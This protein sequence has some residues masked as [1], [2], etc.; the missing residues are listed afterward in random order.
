MTEVTT[1]PYAR[2]VAADEINA[3]PSGK[4]GLDE[5]AASIAAKGLI[6]PLCV[7]PADGNRFEVIDGGRRYRAIGRLVKAKTWK[8][9]TAIP[10]IVRNE[11]DAEALETSLMAN[12][13]RLPMH[14]VDQ[15]MVFARLAATGKSDADIA[16]RFGI[17]ER[18]VRQQQ[19]LGKL[20]PDVLDA[21]R[22][23]KIDAKVAQA[24][25][26]HPDQAVQAAAWQRLKKRGGAVSDY[27][28]RR[29][30]AGDR[31][32]KHGV[33]DDLLELY[34]AA[35]GTVVDDLFGDEAYLEDGA[36]LTTIRARR[37]AEQ[38]EAARTR[39]LG[40][41]WAWVALETDLPHG[42]KWEWEKL[43]PDWPGLS[44]E[45]E[46]RVEAL[47]EKIVAAED[48]DDE[49]IAGRLYAE[50]AAIEEA[51]RMAIFTPE[52]R[53]RS[54]CVLSFYTNGE[55]SI[56]HG[57]VRPSA[58]GTI[59]IETA[60]DAARD[61]S[62]GGI[63]RDEDADAGDHD[64]GDAGGCGAPAVDGDTDGDGFAI[65]QAL[66]QTVSEALTI[67]AARTL[68]GDPDLAMRVIAAALTCRYDAPAVVRSEGHH[69]V[70]KPGERL[71]AERL[72]ELLSTP[73]DGFTGPYGVRDALARAVAGT[74]DLTF[75]RWRY[76]SRDDGVGA[77]VAALP[78]EAFLAMAREAFVVDD[79]FTRASKSVALAAID[80][81]REA[82]CAAGMAPEDTLATMRKADLAAAA[83]R[84]AQACGWLPPE[85]RNA[86]YAPIAPDVPLTG[87]M[88]AAEQTGDRAVAEVGQP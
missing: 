79:Y 32:A 47:A 87:P 2:L 22:K 81:M 46:A 13:V 11:D 19:A 80:E 43:R 39:L 75:T 86:V 23:G 74:L 15:H 12:T 28:V 77:L 73:I 20:A 83:A 9:D 53:A 37:M 33:P 54:G 71:F 36:L 16:A 31:P 52:M 67:A 76:K 6:Q 84:A 29:E 3:R 17:T 30:L 70:R 59:D 57:V 56:A 25:C 45:D 50:L 58:D 8:R 34:L 42:W 49:T 82:G 72:A 64:K 85:L 66:A 40:Q 44:A 62:D 88:A 63:D 51:S 61:H 65:S 60:I 24:F 26:V 14:P 10:V 4:D 27:D 7:R 48:A 35:G 38:S 1:V 55:M 5:L 78:P 21:W 68:S 69:L 41:G 18:T